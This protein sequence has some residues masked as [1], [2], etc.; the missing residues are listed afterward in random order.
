MAKYFSH[1]PYVC[2]LGT[3]IASLTCGQ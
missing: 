3:N 2:H 1:E